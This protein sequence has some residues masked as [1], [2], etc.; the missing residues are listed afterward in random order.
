MICTRKFMGLPTITY[1]RRRILDSPL[2]ALTLGILPLAAAAFLAWGL[3]RSV[4]TA[5][6][7]QN[8]SLAGITAAGGDPDSRRPVRAPVG[9]LPRPPRNRHREALDDDETSRPH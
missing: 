2:D 4:Q 3:T 9:V 5:P 8:W 1:Y 6:A 7:A